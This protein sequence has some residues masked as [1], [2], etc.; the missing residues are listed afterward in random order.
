MEKEFQY[1]SERRKYVENRSQQFVID[2][3]E[4]SYH[5]RLLHKQ[6]VALYYVGCEEGDCSSSAMLGILALQILG[7]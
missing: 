4:H 3:R 1:C 6:F 2:I 7:I 5:Y